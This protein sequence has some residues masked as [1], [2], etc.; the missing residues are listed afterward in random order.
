MLLGAAASSHK[1]SMIGCLMDSSVSDATPLLSSLWI[2]L[3][4]LLK[5]DISMLKGRFETTS[6][7]PSVDT[8]PVLEFFSSALIDVM[9]SKS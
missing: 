4:L 9:F 1:L 7:T 8:I 3:D 5:P 2:L 6:M